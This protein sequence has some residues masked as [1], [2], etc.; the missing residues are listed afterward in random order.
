MSRD[1][2]RIEYIVEVIEIL[3]LLKL[4]NYCSIVL[5]LAFRGKRSWITMAN[6]LLIDIVAFLGEM[7]MMS[8]LENGVNSMNPSLEIDI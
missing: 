3:R 7:E 8:M 6:A 4:I 1:L 5:W 2:R